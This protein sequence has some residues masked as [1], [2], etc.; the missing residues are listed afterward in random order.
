MTISYP[1]GLRTSTL[2]TIKTV[3][4]GVEFD[5]LQFVKDMQL[6][7]GAFHYTQF[8]RLGFYMISNPELM[9]EILVDRPEEFYKL[10]LIK[11]A[12]GPFLGNGL[13]TNEGDFWKRQRKLAQPAF[14]SRRIESYADIMVDYT[15][16]MLASWRTGQVRR[17]DR[18]MMKLT[19]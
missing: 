14:H 18:E 7:F 5:M 13:L 16:R 9:H 15:R 19:L 3:L 6:Q 11:Y 8:G 2:E 4:S 10:K 1:P 12:L 17:L